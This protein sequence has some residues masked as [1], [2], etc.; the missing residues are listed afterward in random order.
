MTMG[1]L[2]EVPKKQG[3]E[4]V[5]EKVLPLAITMDERICSGAYFAAAFRKMGKLLKNPELLETAPEKIIED[6]GIKTRKKKK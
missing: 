1:N 6:S 2:K 5:L 3:D 4:I